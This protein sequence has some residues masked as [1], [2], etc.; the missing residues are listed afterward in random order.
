MSEVFRKIPSLSSATITLGSLATSATVG[1]QATAITLVSSNRVGNSLAVVLTSALTTG[2]IA[3][4]NQVHL[5]MAESYD[6]TNYTT[7]LPA[8]G[9]SDSGYTFTASPVGTTPTPSEFRYI[10]SIRFTAQSQ[11]KRAV[12]NVQNPPTHAVFVVLNNTGIALASSGSGIE[13]AQITDD[14][15]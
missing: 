11:T 10:G 6:G 9:A 13:Y 12:F 2:T 15:V 5:W 4:D 8:V 7:G 3:G 14:I 1:R